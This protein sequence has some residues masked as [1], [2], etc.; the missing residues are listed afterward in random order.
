MSSTDRLQPPSARRSRNPRRGASLALSALAGTALAVALSGLASASTHATLRSATNSALNEAVD[1]NAAGRTVY[2]LRPE[3]AH[4]LLCTSRLCLKFW[5][6]VKGSR[7]ARLV[8]GAGVTGKIK[9]LSRAHGVEQVTLNGDPLY[10]FAGDSANGQ[11]N[12]EKIHSFGGTWLVVGAKSSGPAPQQTNNTTTSS[13][14]TQTY[15]GYTGPTTSS[16]T[17]TG[18]TTTSPTTTTTTSSS[19]STYTYTY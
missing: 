18:T 2:R 13:S 3:T 12:G 14:S 11:A 9:L 19:T 1:V 16:T 6:P 17:S 8:E 15:P 10:T 7:H 5:H 4:H